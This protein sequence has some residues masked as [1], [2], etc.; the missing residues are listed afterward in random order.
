[1]NV[2]SH[3]NTFRTL[4]LALPEV[5]AMPSMAVFYSSMVSCFPIMS[6]RYFLNDFGKVTLSPVIIG[7]TFFLRSTFA[8]IF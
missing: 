7:I 1:M 2:I 3:E 8:V 6:V 4:T 5:C